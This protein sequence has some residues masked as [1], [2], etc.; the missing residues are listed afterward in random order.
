MSLEME[1]LVAELGSL[2]LL[3]S[4]RVPLPKE[5]LVLSAYASPQITHFPVL[6]KS[7]L[8]GPGAAQ[9]IA[10]QVIKIVTIL[11]KIVTIHGHQQL[12][13]KATASNL[14]WNVCFLK[15]FIS[16]TLNF[17]L[18]LTISSNAKLLAFCF[19]KLLIY[20]SL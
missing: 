18:K 8:G 13:S 1:S 16:T 10:T 19:F 5:A 9:D 3:L 7:P 2:A 12:T 15:P 6:H 4:M 17:G 11:I 20:K 14:L